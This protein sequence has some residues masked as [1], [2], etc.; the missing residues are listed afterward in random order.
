MFKGKKAAKHTKVVINHNAGM[1]HNLFI[2]GNGAGL[3]WKKGIQL[4]NNGP[5][6]WVWETDAPFAECEFKV[7]IDDKQYE[8]G[9]NHHIHSGGWLRFS[10]RF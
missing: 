7:L 8:Q 6:E 3:N 2:R 9:E 1:N 10:P 4:R 5:D